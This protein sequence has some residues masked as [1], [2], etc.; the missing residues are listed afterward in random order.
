MGCVPYVGF[1]TNR[2]ATV[3]IPFYMVLLEGVLGII[4][5]ELDLVSLA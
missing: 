1:V 2:H 5:D 3:M 4:F